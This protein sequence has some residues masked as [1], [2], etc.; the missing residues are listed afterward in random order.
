MV[1]HPRALLQS[2]TP[3]KRKSES[4]ILH[5]PFHLHVTEGIPQAV[6][7]LTARFSISLLLPGFEI[8]HYMKL[9][10]GSLKHAQACRGG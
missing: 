8:G 2:L 6:L 4:V 9:D 1:Q 5:S 7:L 10:P 3:Q